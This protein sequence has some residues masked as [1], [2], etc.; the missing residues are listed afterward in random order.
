MCVNVRA[1]ACCRGKRGSLEELFSSVALNRPPCSIFTLLLGLSLPFS[2]LCETVTN[3]W[4][5]TNMSRLGKLWQLDAV[6]NATLR[7]REF[8]EL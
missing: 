1:T 2:L 7:T 4:L 5:I 8:I 3:S 6:C